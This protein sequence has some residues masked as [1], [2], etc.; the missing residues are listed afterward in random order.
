MARFTNKAREGWL[1]T[2]QVMERLWIVL[3]DFPYCGEWWRFH[4]V[5]SGKQKTLSL[6]TYPLDHAQGCSHKARRDAPAASL[7]R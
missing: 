6:E 1:Q 4:Y 2:G 3:T 5:F 7:W